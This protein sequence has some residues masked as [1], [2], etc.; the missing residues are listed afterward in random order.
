MANFDQA[1]PLG[2]LYLDS[3][4]NKRWVL[5]FD[6]PKTLAKIDGVFVTIEPTGG[7]RKPSGKP[8]LFAYL[9]VEPNHP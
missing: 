2:I 8:V 4:T 1:L 9:K 5:K 7:S 6:D 3:S